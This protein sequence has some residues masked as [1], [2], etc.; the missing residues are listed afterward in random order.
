MRPLEDLMAK[1]DSDRLTEATIRLWRNMV[2]AFSEWAEESGVADA[3]TSAAEAFEQGVEAVIREVTEAGEVWKDKARKTTKSRTG[4]KSK[5]K[6]K[7]GKK[8]KK[9]RKKAGKKSRKKSKKKS[10]SR[11]K[12]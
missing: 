1:T 7:S 6:P 8:T 4:K 11:K 9:K 3:T 12:S 2:T 5:K 10:G